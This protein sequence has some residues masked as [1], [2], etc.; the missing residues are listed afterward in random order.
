MLKEDH[1][2]LTQYDVKEKSVISMSPTESTPLA[3]EDSYEMMEP[4]DIRQRSK[5]RTSSGA[6]VISHSAVR[7][8]ARAA[9]I[10]AGIAALSAPRET[11]A[12]FAHNSEWPYNSVDVIG[13]PI[14]LDSAY[15]GL[16]ELVP[17]EVEG[18][19]S[20]VQ[21]APNPLYESAAVDNRS[22]TTDGYVGGS[23]GSGSAGLALDGLP[24][25]DVSTENAGSSHEFGLGI[26]NLYDVGTPTQPT[27][28]ADTMSAFEEDADEYLE[29]NESSARGYAF[30]AFEGDE[31]LDISD[32]G[33]E[34]ED[35]L[36]SS[37]QMKNGG[38][39]EIDA[40][41]LLKRHGGERDEAEEQPLGFLEGAGIAL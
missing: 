41:A 20:T 40:Q 9:E 35:A 33:S 32:G 1:R 31:Y 16:Y 23:G 28:S 37:S 39:F 5:K 6:A 27:T 15:A 30:G 8:A 21:L 11:V 3:E 13:A 10:E 17:G 12:R 26:E 25:I 4:E 19:S 36:P 34:D 24:N 38:S 22:S 29:V 14:D 7:N 2:R 18:P